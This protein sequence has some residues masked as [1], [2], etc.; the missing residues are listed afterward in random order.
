MGSEMCIRDRRLGA[1]IFR[2]RNQFAQMQIPEAQSTGVAPKNPAPGFLHMQW[3]SWGASGLA[4]VWAEENT[5]DSIF[6]A[7]RRK[8]TFATSG[9]RLKLRLFAGYNLGADLLNDAQLVKKAYARG[10][11]MGADLKAKGGRAPDML[12]WATRDPG[13]AP[14]QRLQ[15]IKGWIDADGKT[16]EQVYDVA[17]AGGATP[18]PQTKRCP[19]NNAQVDVTDCSYSA[20][21][22]ADELKAHWRDPDYA[23]GE[24]AFYYARGL[25]NPTCRWS[26][27]DAMRAGSPLN[28]SLPATI[29][30][31]VWSSPIWLEH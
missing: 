7:M 9:P 6:A 2:L 15:I 12:V 11:S 28:P 20:D 31:R 14:L 19:D 21:S 29:Q 8:E 17:C 13:S 24:N 16:H 27:W 23:A 1:Q 5:R 22:G 30:E 4:G 25:E 10:V 26:T 3:S 18:D